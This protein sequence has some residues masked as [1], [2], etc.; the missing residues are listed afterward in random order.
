[1][2]KLLSFIAA[3]GFLCSGATMAQTKNIIISGRIDSTIVKYFELNEIKI[4]I[5]DRASKLTNDE[6]VITVPVTP[7]RKFKAEIPANSKLVYLSFWALGKNRKNAFTPIQGQTRF[8]DKYEELYLFERGDSLKLNIWK[9]G[10]MSFT[11]KGSEKLKLQSYLYNLPHTYESLSQRYVDLRNQKKFGELLPSFVAALHTDNSIRKN[12]IATYKGELPEDV[13]QILLIDALSRT[14]IEITENLY[15]TSG[16]EFADELSN[17]V[18]L[19]QPESFNA[20]YINLSAF[21]T[22]LIFLRELNSY[23]AKNAVNRKENYFKGLYPILK[24]KYTGPFREDLLLVASKRAPSD[25]VRPFIN[26]LMS[27]SI[28][29][30]NKKAFST[31]KAK[32]FS[33]AYPFALS[34]QNGLIHNLSDYKG[35]VVVMDLWFTGCGGCIWLNT[36]M[37]QIVE[38]YKDNKDIVFLTVSADTNKEQWLKSIPTERYTS[39]GTVNLYTNGKGFDDPIWTYY[40]F[41]GGPNQLIIGK[42]GSLISSRPPNLVLVAQKNDNGELL[43][44]G[45]LETPIGKEFIN[46]LDKALL[47][48]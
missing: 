8:A 32:E 30:L 3:I 26:D 15:F 1:M 25:F 17:A 22:D 10:K 33:S 34:D 20:K 16:V 2:K 40:G 7:D 21:Y 6:Q 12:L 44:S 14:E 46:M 43:A 23:G 45:L 9:D 13:Y 19:K 29:P 39:P 27:I 38:K 41:I 31:W 35:K 28:D 11:G 37:R 47:K 5:F 24:R 36:A 42:D 18:R 4:K 48:N